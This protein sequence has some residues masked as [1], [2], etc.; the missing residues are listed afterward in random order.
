M[1]KTTGNFGGTVSV[2]AAIPLA[3]V[4]EGGQWVLNKIRDY[5]FKRNVRKMKEREAR[6]SHR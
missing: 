2:I 1:P 6:K 4:Y 5:N 3:L